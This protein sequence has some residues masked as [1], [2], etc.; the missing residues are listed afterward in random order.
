M[1]YL[2]TGAR[3]LGEDLDD[4]YLPGGY[5]LINEAMITFAWRLLA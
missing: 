5:Q 1:E 3:G 4:K 2:F